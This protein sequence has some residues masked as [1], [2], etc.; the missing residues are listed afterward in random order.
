MEARLLKPWLHKVEK[1][2]GASS[3]NARNTNA[4]FMH[5]EKSILI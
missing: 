3:K 4:Y 5:G 2:S 1:D